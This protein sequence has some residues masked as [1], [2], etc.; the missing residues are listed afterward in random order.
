VNPPRVALIGGIRVVVIPGVA[1]PVA[2]PT[3][4]PSSNHNLVVTTAWTA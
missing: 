2:D 1:I 3:G 4:R